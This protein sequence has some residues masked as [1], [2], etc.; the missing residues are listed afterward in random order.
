ME[1]LDEFLICSDCF[2]DEGLKLDAKYIGIENTQKCKN[3][4]SV[5]G[6][7]LNYNL[8]RDLCYRFFT[9]GTI[10]KTEYGGFP[11]IIYNDKF[12]ETKID[13]SPWLENDVKLIAYNAK[14]NFFYYGPRFWM[15]GEIEPLKALQDHKER[16]K[17]IERIIETYPIR[18]LTTDESFY[19]IRVN[20][21]IPHDNA[22]YDS[23]PD[24]F[25]KKGR[26]DDIDF[27]VLYASQDIEICIHECRVSA[28]DDIFMSKLT[29]QKKLK[30]LDLS[31]VIYE[32][33]V[34]EFESL[35]I[36]IQ[37]LFLAEKH[38]YEIC[39]NIAKSARMKGFDGII[40]PSYFSH[41][42]TGTVPFETSYGISLRRF[43]NLRTYVKKQ[44]ISNLVI[45]GRP[46]S[47]NK[48]RVECINRVL[49]N[50]VQYDISFG[51]AFH[52]AFE[53]EENEND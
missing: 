9:R 5:E 48:V 2:K 18:Y 22:E 27:P 3:C 53:N 19:R 42:R 28:E 31:E 10:Y 14:V 46:I 43:D 52:K 51:P 12:E 44:I 6:Y 4:N 13:F 35:G 24:E 32:P 30:L 49:L 29:P 17:I 39:R 16:A 40:Y 15:F 45:F 33:E 20:P 23:A 47:E 34:T 41:L 37:F 50:K 38:S 11:L 25:M 36:S 7:K 8:I 26:F 1:T 21:K